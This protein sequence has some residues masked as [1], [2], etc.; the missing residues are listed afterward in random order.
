MAWAKAEQEGRCVV[1]P[2]NWSVGMINGIMSLCERVRAMRIAKGKDDSPIITWQL[3]NMLAKS[4]RAEAEAALKG[5][6]GWM[7]FRRR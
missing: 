4:T 7:R 2:E 6:E 3:Y 5:G 1:L